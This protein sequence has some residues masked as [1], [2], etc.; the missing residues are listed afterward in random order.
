MLRLDLPEE[1][2][3]RSLAYSVFTGCCLINSVGA[4]KANKLSNFNHRETL[5]KIILSGTVKVIHILFC[6]LSGSMQ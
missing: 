2:L 1:N 6:K 5:K 4:L 3:W